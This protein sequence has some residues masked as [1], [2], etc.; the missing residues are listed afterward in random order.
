MRGRLVLIVGP[1]F[2]GKNSVGVTAVFATHRIIYVTY[3]NQR[4][5]EFSILRIHGFSNY[6]V[7]K[8][9]ALRNLCSDPHG[10]AFGNSTPIVAN[11]H[12]VAGQSR[13]MRRNRRRFHQTGTGPPFQV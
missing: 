2:A 3:R 12:L 7:G 5:G 10:R 4:V 13:S 8:G 1:T 9:W 11:I 6:V